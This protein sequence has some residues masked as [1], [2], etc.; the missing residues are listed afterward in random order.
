MPLSRGTN[1]QS[2]RS[3]RGKSVDFVRRMFLLSKV[4]GH[5][6]AHGLAS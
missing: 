4:D 5:E 1:Q 3:R 2:R 6:A